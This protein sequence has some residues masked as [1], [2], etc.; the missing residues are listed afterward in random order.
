[1]QAMAGAPVDTYKDIPEVLIVK[2]DTPM[3][4]VGFSKQEM[5]K[6]DNYISKIERM[7]QICGPFLD[8]LVGASG[9]TGDAKFHISTFLKQFFNNEIKNARSIGN[10]DEALYDLANFYH[11]KTSKELAKIKTVANLTKKRNLVYQSENY[12]VDNVYKFK[13]M[14]TLYKEPKQSSKWL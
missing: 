4:R 12:L 8:E 5:T 14:L 9:S 2:N 6:F 3:D 11:E 13:A 10:I 7:C 1:M